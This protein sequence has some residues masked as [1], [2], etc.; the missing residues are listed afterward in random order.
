[1]ESESAASDTSARSDRA[2]GT[3][4]VWRDRSQLTYPFRND[5]CA[6]ATDLSMTS[7]ALFLGEPR[8]ISKQS[9]SSTLTDGY[10]VVNLHPGT[11]LS[12]YGTVTR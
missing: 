2:T 6:L 12:N 1:M 10:H 9:P 7:F 8:L 3:D 11:C 4:R 5:L